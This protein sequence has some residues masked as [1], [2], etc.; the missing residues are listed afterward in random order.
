MDRMQVFS[1]AELRLIHEASMQVLAETGVKFNA[2]EAIEI[3]KKR[4]FCTDGAR[5]FFTE[6]QVD[7]AIGTT[8]SKF[9][10]QA[11]K[12]E[13]SVTIGEDNFVFLPTGGAPNVVTSDGEMRTATF[14]DYENA[15]LSIPEHQWFTVLCQH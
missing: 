2:P 15:C 5:V 1:R 9:E 13:N 3:F 7:K 4:G 8:P 14:A 11:R 12:Q 6:K 10:I